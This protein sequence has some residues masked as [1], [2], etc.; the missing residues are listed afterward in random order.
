MYF[1]DFEDKR[2]F[3]C[4]TESFKWIKTI[5]GETL[6]DLASFYRNS[7]E[8]N[9][10]WK[11]NYLRKTCQLY[12][13]T[14]QFYANTLEKI[15][16][17]ECNAR[18]LSRWDIYFKL[19]FV[20]LMLRVHFI[21]AITRASNICYYTSCEKIQNKIIFWGTKVAFSIDELSSSINLY[22]ATSKKVSF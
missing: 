5:V 14:L 1:I 6:P 8:T 16:L 4:L 17:N 3:Y 12:W 21:Q 18:R 19:I 13:E 2:Y 15:Q 11:L 22:L 7:I 9:K 20:K 10:N